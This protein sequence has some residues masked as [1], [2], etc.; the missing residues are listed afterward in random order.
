MWIKTGDIN[1]IS[2]VLMYFFRNDQRASWS[3]LG[4]INWVHFS[5]PH[6]QV[7]VEPDE[8]L[9]HEDML[10]SPI[11]IQSDQVPML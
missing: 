1:Q 6:K 3:F 8:Y 5:Y 9:Y 2:I 4:F 10:N 11:G 7:K